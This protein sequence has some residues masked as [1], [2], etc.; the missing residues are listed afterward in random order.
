MSFGWIDAEQFSFN[1]LLLMDRWLFNTITKNKNPEFRENLAVALAGNP[2]V[3]W[4]IVNKCPEKQEYYEEL[5]KK[6]PANLSEEVI[7]DA[8]VYVLDALDWAVV[9]VYPELTESLSYVKDWD[10]ER[11]LSITDFTN[12]TVLDIGSGTGRLAFAAATVAMYV[13]ASEPVDRMR[14]YMREKQKRLKVGNIYVVDGTIEMLPFPDESFDIV[15]SGHVIGDDCQAEWAEMSRVTKIG[16]WVIDC[17]G[18]DDRKKPEGPSKELIEI[19]FEY[20]HYVSKTGGD[21]YRYW[22]QK[23]E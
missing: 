15:M 8:E 17:P 3:F 12:K 11:L 1:T 6:A 9:Y 2:V 21:V 7:R 5:L 23:L 13:I 14:E 18:E 16:G 10:K 22:K 19:G 4:Y 20:S